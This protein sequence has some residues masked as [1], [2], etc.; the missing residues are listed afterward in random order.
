MH[1]SQSLENKSDHV[2]NL[3]N[4][5]M[6]LCFRV[7][8]AKEYDSPSVLLERPS[9]FSALVQEYSNRSSGL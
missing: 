7:G 3:V 5:C 8:W 6:L 4:V 1:S 2:N 9:L